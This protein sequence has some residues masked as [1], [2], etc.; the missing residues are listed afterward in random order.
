[1]D[2]QGEKTARTLF[3]GQVCYSGTSCAAVLVV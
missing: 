2:M 3:V 1:M